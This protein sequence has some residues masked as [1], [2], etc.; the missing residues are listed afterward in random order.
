MAAP[1]VRP[2]VLAVALMQ[3]CLRPTFDVLGE[4]VRFSSGARGDLDQLELAI[5]APRLWLCMTARF[6]FSLLTIARLL[7]K[8]AVRDRTARA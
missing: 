6:A 5:G 4:T 3:L 1:D 7:R 2:L 8:S